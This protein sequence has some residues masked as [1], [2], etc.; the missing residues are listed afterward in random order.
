MTRD[1]RQEICRVKWIKSK[2]RGTIE[3]C[4]G[5]GK[6]RCAINCINT[7]LSK[8]PNKRI[9]I[10]VPTTGLKEQWERHVDNYSLTFN[11]EVQVI[12]TVIKHKWKCDLLIIDEIHRAVAD[13][14]SQVFECVKYNLI[15]GLTATIERLDGK[16]ILLK[17]YCPVCD[18][19]TLVE[20]QVNGWVSNFTEYMVMLEVHDIEQYKTLNKEFQQHFDF[21]GSVVPLYSNI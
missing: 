15:L 5:F 17:K 14:L 9:L 16:E 8:Y 18:S 1:E 10:V 2:C 4:T 13:Q 11:C 6:S 19:V 3:A 12:N 20:A 7:I 21:F